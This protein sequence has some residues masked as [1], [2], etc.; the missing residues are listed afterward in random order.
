M[1]KAYILGAIAS[2]LYFMNIF[3]ME[4]HQKCHFELSFKN[5]F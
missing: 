1:L 2:N 4:K 5:I 3:L